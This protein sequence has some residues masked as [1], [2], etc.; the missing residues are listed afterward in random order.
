MHEPKKWD[1]TGDCSIIWSSIVCTSC[2]ILDEIKETETDGACGI[3]GKKKNVYGILVK[4]RA[5]DYS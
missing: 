4:K 5:R 3:C 2:Q 1:V